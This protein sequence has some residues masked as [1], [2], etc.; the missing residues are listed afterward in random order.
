MQGKK[1]S[2]SPNK[3][4]AGLKTRS[5]SSVNETRPWK[6]GQLQFRS[7]WYLRPLRPYY[8]NKSSVVNSSVWSVTVTT[9]ITAILI[10]HYKDWHH[11]QH[12]EHEYDSSNQLWRKNWQ[13]A[14]WWHVVQSA[15]A[16]VT[17][18]LRHLCF[19]Q[20][21]IIPTHSVHVFANSFNKASSFDQNLN[22]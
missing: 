17:L 21:S 20:A 9:I 2:L 7:N 14:G 18:Q 22:H 16:Q 11:G 15:V 6:P 19:K 4:Q 5:R 8:Q 10:T 12:H 1:A 13:R 3:M